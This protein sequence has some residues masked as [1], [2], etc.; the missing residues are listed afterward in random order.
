MAIF[1]ND[2]SKTEQKK[3]EMM[4]KQNKRKNNCVHMKNDK[5]IKKRDGE[6]H[7]IFKIYF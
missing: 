5:G 1:D 4:G 7:L 3:F 2:N 6:E